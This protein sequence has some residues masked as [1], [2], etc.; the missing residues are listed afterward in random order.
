MY[1]KECV[2]ST[3]TGGTLYFEVSLMSQYSLKTIKVRKLSKEDKRR[4]QRL[5]YRDN[6]V[7]R[8]WLACPYVNDIVTLARDRDGIIRGWCYGRI[9]WGVS[10]TGVY[11]QTSYRRQGIGT[12]LIN[13]MKANLKRRG[14]SE[15]LAYLNCASKLYSTIDEKFRNAEED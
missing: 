10:C 1:L 11:V 8:A 3:P 13:R 15:I 4:C 7:L 2:G 6:S 12:K 9:H 14:A 5:T